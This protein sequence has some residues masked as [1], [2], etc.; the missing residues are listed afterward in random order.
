MPGPRRLAPGAAAAHLLLQLAARRVSR[1]APV[2]ARSRRSTRT[3]SFPTR[4]LSISEGAL[5]PWSVGN[6]GFYESVI[7]AIADR[8]E[9]RARRAVGE[10]DRGAAGSLPLRHRGRAALRQLPQPDGPA[11]LLHARLRGHHPE[12]RAALPRNRLLD[13]ARAD[14]G[15]HVVP[16]VPG[17]QGRAAEA[18]GARGHRRRE[19]HPR[20]HADV[21]Y[22]RAGVPRSS[23]S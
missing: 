15:V 5:V 7:Q 21:R 8:Y 19:E 9:I 3:C 23:S 14:R 10:P 12:P 1:A 11:P 2:S 13:A 20:V 22:P 6:S 4:R 18:G 17:L 16:A